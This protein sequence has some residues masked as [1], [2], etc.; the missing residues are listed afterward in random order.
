MRSLFIL[1]FIACSIL[2]FSAQA[3]LSDSLTGTTYIFD[4]FL[5]SSSS[6]AGADELNYGSLA[7]SSIGFSSANALYNGLLIGYSCASILNTIGGYENI[8]S[9]VARLYFYSA[10]GTTKPEVLAIRAP[11]NWTEGSG[12]GTSSP[13]NG[14]SRRYRGTGTSD[15]S[16]L[17][18]SGEW[19]GYSLYS[20]PTWPISA[21][22]DFKAVS[23]DPVTTIT[24]ANAFYSWNVTTQLTDTFAIGQTYV[25]ILFADTT[26][27]TTSTNE[28]AAVLAS[29]HAS[30][31]Q[32]PVLLFYYHE[33]PV[34]P[35]DFTQDDSC[36]FAGLMNGPSCGWEID[37]SA[38]T[39][40]TL[41]PLGGIGEDYLRRW[42]LGTNGIH[43]VEG[44]PF[45]TGYCREV[46]TYYLSN[47]SYSDLTMTGRNI[48]MSAWVNMLTV[49]LSG[50]SQTVFGKWKGGGA[51][52]GDRAYRL[53]VVG[54]GSGQYVFNLVLSSDSENRN[55]CVSTTAC[56]D[57]TWYH[58]AATYDGSYMRIY[59]DGA[60]TDSVAYSSGIVAQQNAYFTIGS[61]HLGVWIMG[62]SYVDEIGLWQR[63]LTSL[64][65]EALYTYG[66]TGD[67]ATSDY[68]AYT[69]FLETSVFPS[70][71]DAN[72]Y[73][74]VNDSL[75]AISAA[76]GHQ[77][78]VLDTSTEGR[79]LGAMIINGSNYGKTAF[80]FG[81]VHG[82][83]DGDPTSEEYVP[84]ISLEMMRYFAMNP[85]YQV[86]VIFA[87]LM[88]PDGVIASSRLNANSYNINRNYADTTAANN[89]EVITSPSYEAS[90]P[91]S[92][93]EVETQSVR[94]WTLYYSPNLWID[95]HGSS[96]QIIAM[97]YDTAGTTL[98]NDYLQE[99]GLGPYVRNDNFGYAN[100]HNYG[101]KWATQQGLDHCW[102][103]E[104]ARY[105]TRHEEVQ[106]MI[107][108]MTVQFDEIDSLG[109]SG[110]LGWFSKN[111][112]LQFPCGQKPFRQ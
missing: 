12:N 7:N 20:S 93:S 100:N 32:T 28:R 15:W 89:F 102:L 52:S 35:V 2:A 23:G 74:E 37:A 43:E 17:A 107:A 38:S 57:S 22:T 26:H 104:T 34:E 109:T 27:S 68:P 92:F 61:S 30:T 78:V 59:V 44:M 97:Q 45:D 21:W 18:V 69:T 13:T 53:G 82:D 51:G 55:N 54:R 66:I 63:A 65:I 31:T 95:I 83:L 85:P 8:D 19:T 47:S 6:I 11:S 86:R 62:K 36:V 101:F 71:A 39:H 106:R 75:Q 90:G 73:T 79:D 60:I 40:D 98:A 94:D 29:E 108:F 67:T 10:D 77:Y 46:G 64:E 80:I 49:P 87:P 24:T 81:G 84:L 91:D 99:H 56:N 33:S 76:Y 58:V 1:I 88:N 16:G 5:K 25:S 3:Q 72:I 41:T 48:T 111:P 14:V 4:A 50:D 103:Y 9:V 96:D 42:E 105:S 70:V 112:F 110:S